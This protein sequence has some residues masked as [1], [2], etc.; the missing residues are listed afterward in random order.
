MCKKDHRRQNV[1]GCC[2]KKYIMTCIHTA[3]EFSVFPSKS[4]DLSFALYQYYW[5]PT[6]S[7]LYKYLSSCKPYNYSKLEIN[8]LVKKN[9]FL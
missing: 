8:I 9:I 3:K 5:Q 2:I 4:I 1:Y 6:Q 7:N